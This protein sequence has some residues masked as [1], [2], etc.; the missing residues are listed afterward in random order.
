MEVQCDKTE[1]HVEH[2]QKSQHPLACFHSLASN[3]INLS[4]LSPMRA[5]MAGSIS[6]A[7]TSTP[8]APRKVTCQGARTSY[9]KLTL[10]CPFTGEYTVFKAEP[11]WRYSH[12]VHPSEYATHPTFSLHT[13]FRKHYTG[14]CET[15]YTF[16]LPAIKSLRAAY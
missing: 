15:N 5:R 14:L 2:R 7:Y 11:K 13:T 16:M 1:C 3:L 6:A 10:A 4:A 12:A 8:A 9:S